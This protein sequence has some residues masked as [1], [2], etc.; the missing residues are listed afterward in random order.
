MEKQAECS[1]FKKKSVTLHRDFESD[2]CR[3]LKLK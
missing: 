2:V 3:Y 1:K